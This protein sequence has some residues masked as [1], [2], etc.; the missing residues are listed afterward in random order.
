M[1]KYNNEPNSMDNPKICTW[2]LLDVGNTFIFKGDYCI[3][4]KIYYNR[5]VYK[6]QNSEVTGYMSFDYYSTTQ[7]FKARFKNNFAKSKK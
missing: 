4:T 2:N 6:I 3:V 5:F 1:F 7:S